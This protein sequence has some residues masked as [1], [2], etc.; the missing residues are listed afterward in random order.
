MNTTFI[1]LDI[2]GVLNSMDYAK[3]EDAAGRR[4]SIDFLDPDAVQAMETFLRR[5]HNPQVVIS[6]TW[7][8]HHSYESLTE[9]LPGIMK[10]CN[11]EAWQTGNS[12]SGVRALE[13][14]QYLNALLPDDTFRRFNNYLCIDDDGDFFQHQ[15]LYQT[16][17]KV[18]FTDSDISP[19]LATVGRKP[20]KFYELGNRQ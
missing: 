11:K 15:P 10:Y 5:V 3:R 12:P 13:V 6:S 1:F 17:Y 2:D 14:D 20:V 19:A 16:S 4:L 18:G 7:R 9:L 8:K